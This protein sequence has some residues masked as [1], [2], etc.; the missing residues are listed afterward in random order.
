MCV[1]EARECAQDQEKCEGTLHFCRTRFGL[2]RD[3][4]LVTMGF[5]GNP[6]NF[7]VK[8]SVNPSV[9]V[10]EDASVQLSI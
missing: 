2:V 8:R 4:K 7:G 1:R 6:S 3:R 9:T 10:L 5:G